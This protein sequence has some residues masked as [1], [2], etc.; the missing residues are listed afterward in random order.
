[1][2]GSSGIPDGVHGF[3]PTLYCRFGGVPQLPLFVAHGRFPA[4]DFPR[5]AMPP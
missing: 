3:Q 5:H 4:E 1:M 2:Q